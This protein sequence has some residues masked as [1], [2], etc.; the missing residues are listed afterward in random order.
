MARIILKFDTAE[1]LLAEF[2]LDASGPSVTLQ[3][4]PVGQQDL[5]TGWLR[6]LTPAQARTLATALEGKAKEIN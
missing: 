3:V 5:D 4:G 1:G 6:Y 2:I